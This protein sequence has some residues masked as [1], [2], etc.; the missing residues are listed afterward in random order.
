MSPNA[1]AEP[2][3]SATT[4][5]RMNAGAILRIKPPGVV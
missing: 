4:V 1:S 3:A 2:L 5:V